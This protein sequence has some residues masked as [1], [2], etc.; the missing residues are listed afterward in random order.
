VHGIYSS[1]Q[2]PIDVRR[3]ELLVKVLASVEQA[4]ACLLPQGSAVDEPVDL[5][6]FQ[7]PEAPSL[8]WLLQLS[9]DKLLQEWLLLLLDHPK[10]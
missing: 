8:S 7:K 6:L 5:M 3:R 9:A 10:A 1:Q 2:R 4:H